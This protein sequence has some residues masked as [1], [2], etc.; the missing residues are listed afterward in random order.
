VHV[1]R[2][3]GHGKEHRIEIDAVIGWDLVAGD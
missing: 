1:P 2:G 3:F